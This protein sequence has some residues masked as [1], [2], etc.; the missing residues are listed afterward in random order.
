VASPDHPIGEHPAVD[1]PA[2]VTPHSASGSGAWDKFDRSRGGGV[3]V[4][5]GAASSPA[6]VQHGFGDERTPDASRN[7]AGSAPG[8]N[9]PGAYPGQYRQTWP[10]AKQPPSK[11]KPT[12]K[13]DAPTKKP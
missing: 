6:K 11:A 10:P 2:A 8:A 1:R 9:H 5:D 7:G 4:M 3:P 12:Q 13:K